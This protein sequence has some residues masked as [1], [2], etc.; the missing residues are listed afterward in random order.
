M[1]SY[2][3]LDRAF[4]ESCSGL[5]LPFCA[6]FNA[7]PASGAGPIPITQTPERRPNVRSWFL[8]DALARPNLKLASGS[9]VLRLAIKGRMVAAAQIISG[10]HSEWMEASR[11]VLCAGAI[12]SP[13]ILLRSGI[14]PADELRRTET[15]VSTMLNGVGRSLRDHVALW[16]GFEVGRGQ[17]VPGAPWFQVMLRRRADHTRGVPDFSLEV[18]H[19]FRLAPS[20][21]AYRRAVLTLGLLSPSATGSVQLKPA[22]PEDLPVV[23][24]PFPNPADGESMKPLLDLGSKLL[25]S[26]AFRALDPS[27][28]MLM[29][30][31]SHGGRTERPMARSLPFNGIDA[32]SLDACFTSMHHLH[33]SCRMGPATDPSSVVDERFR[34]HGLDNLYVADASVIPIQFRA[35]T[36]LAALMIGERA[37][38]SL[39]RQ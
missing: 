4:L 34:V 39:G 10:D 16:L 3:P 26:A 38:Q 2:Q 18:F 8:D 29:T 23:R 6:D 13:E 11:F 31:V 21:A 20:P 33:G 1:S 22:A 17:G 24:L 7:P 5:D 9:R 37:A 19:D 25:D 27:A 15:P 14:G 35:N 28:R 36:H 32:A 12:G 30:V